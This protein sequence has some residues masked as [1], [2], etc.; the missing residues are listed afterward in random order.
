MPT[1][2]TPPPG[3]APLREREAYLD[4][5]IGDVL[6]RH[7]SPATHGLVSQ[8]RALTQRRRRDPGGDA[9]D[10]LVALVDS[11]DV[12]TAIEVVRAS[13]LYLQLANLAE[14]A[15]RERLRRERAISGEPPFTASLEAMSLPDE[16]ERA[17]AILAAMD[18]SLVFTAHPTEVQRRTVIEK[19]EAIGRLLR[20]LDDRRNTPEERRVLERELRAQIVLLWAGNELYLTPPTVADEIRNV[21]AWFRETLVDEATA[22]FERLDDLFHERYDAPLP[23]PT[24]LRFSSWIGGDRDGNPNV[25]PATTELAL[26]MGRDFILERYVREIEALQTRLSQDARRGHVG[27]ELAASIE[28]DA[29]E[30]HDVHNTL[31]PRQAAEPYRRKLA[32]MH[33][34]L[35]CSL[36]D[37]AGAYASWRD[38]ADELDLLARSVETGSGRDVAAPVRRVHRMVEIFRFTSYELEWRQNKRDLEGATCEIVATVEPAVD[39]AHANEDERRTWLE[40]ELVGH[41]PLF[42]ERMRLSPSARDVVA[43]LQAVARARAR[44]GPDAIETLVLAGSENASDVLHLLLVAREC[45]ALDAGPLQIVPLFESIPTLRAAPGVVRALF[46][47]PAFAAHLASLGNV[48]EVMVGYS[49]SNKEGG[50]VTSTWEIYR[51][52]R[53]IARVARQ[54]GIAIRF[55]HGRGGSI[56][57]GVADPRRSIADAPPSARSW[58]FKQTEQG[59]VIASRYGLPSLARRSLEIVATALFG[60]RPADSIEEPYDEAMDRIAV[61]A[62]DAYRALVDAPHFLE[63]FEACTPINEIGDMQISSR[64]A[65]RRATSSIDDLRAVPWSFAWTQTRAIVASWYGFGSALRDE[66]ANGRRHALREMF[67]TYPFFASLVDKVE[68]GLAT[69]DLAIFELYAN[70]LVADAGVRATFV[71]RIRSEYADA[72]AGLFAVTGRDR[73]LAS[74]PVSATALAVRNPYVDPMSYLQIRLIR[75]F[76][77]TAR[78]DDR[79]RDA[80]RLS[81]N[82]IAAGLRVTG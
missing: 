30:L 47:S 28:R 23:V 61:R 81:I 11:L 3:P 33:R 67:A 76:R 44:H 53:E 63:F 39:Y 41:R 42:S 43:S 16:A 38:F 31:G 24:F 18:V 75:D 9:H 80:I 22:L 1:T 25:T 65:R 13:S 17:R 8:I 34:R 27:D 49:D 52:Q 57:R 46:A 26:E 36:R 19:H 50:I 14:H 5:L 66:L 10:A 74:D 62:H 32:F 48:C 70:A 59:E 37:E 72:C 60:Q 71:E 12:A 6:E 40:R 68:R 29:A 73:L 54:Y 20:T 56:A 79:L 55:F 35:R 51:A 2:A 4:A 7:A 64:P 21:I 78:T 15:H 77:A 69:A 58:S 45:G 82:G